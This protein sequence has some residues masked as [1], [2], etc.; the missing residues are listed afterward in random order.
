LFP[1]IRMTMS[2]QSVP[3]W[4]ATSVNR[5]ILRAVSVVTVA[6]LLVKIAGLCKDVTV[7]GFFGCSDAMDAYLAAALVPALLINLIS[8]SMNQ[9]LVPTLI[10]VKELE[11]S[12]AA[13]R[14]FSSSMLIVSLML[15]TVSV[16]LALAAR[17]IMPL[18]ASHYAPAKLALAVRI[19]YALL[20][21]VLITGIA[22]NCT[23]VLNAIDRFALPALAPVAVSLATITAA[24]SFGNQISIWAI[25]IGNLAGSCIHAVAMAWMVHLHGFRFRLWWY[26]NSHAAREVAGQYWPV[27][28]SS[29]VASGGLLVDQSMAAM[30]PP[31]S[32]S[33]L[34]YANRFVSV[35]LT[36][37]AGAVSTAIVPHFSRLIA[38]RDWA[39]CR[40]VLRT[41]L[42]LSAL[43]SIPIAAALIAGSHW[44]IR[45]TLEHG[46]FTNEQTALVSPVLGLCAIQ[47]PF[48]VCSRVFY[49]FLVAMRRTDLVLLCGVLNLVLDIFL[50]LILMRW[51]GLAGI[52]LATSL[53]TVST[54][55]FLWFWTYRVLPG[56]PDVTSTPEIVGAS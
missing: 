43:T 24:L 18:F 22:S 52:A 4:A 31:G 25:V 53:W 32:V 29:V 55:F 9:A 17:A 51:F 20:P 19:V 11:G 1:V 44:L 26:G 8:E 16:G 33:V 14:L 6:T 15:A 48:F 46:A 35:V 37:L 23:A 10:R 13:Q 40:H 21:L 47:I 54:F 12:A 42:R 2:L 56:T 49:R 45:A 30:L 50:N 3:S 38:Y 7:A 34:V 41:W 27:F 36:L 5:S 28:F 39:G